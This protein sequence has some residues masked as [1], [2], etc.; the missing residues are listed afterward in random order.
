M[1]K[2]L[3]AT[4]TLR[5]GCSKVDPQT[6]KQTHRQGR[7]QYTAHLGAQCNQDHVTL[8]LGLAYA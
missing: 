4:Q 8:G 3:E 6:D 7:L 2:R 5:A 1:K